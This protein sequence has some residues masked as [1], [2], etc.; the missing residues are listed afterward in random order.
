M[1]FGTVSR[2]TVLPN[3]EL[4]LEKV[5]SPFKGGGEHSPHSLIVS[6]DGKSLYGI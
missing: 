5:I 4:G 2:T 3:G 6:E 1:R